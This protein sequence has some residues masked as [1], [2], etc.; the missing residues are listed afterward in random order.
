MEKV[1]YK[2]ICDQ[3]FGKAETLALFKSPDRE[4]FIRYL[5]E[6][7]VGMVMARGQAP[8]AEAEYRLGAIEAVDSVMREL[9]TLDK[10]VESAIKREAEERKRKAESVDAPMRSE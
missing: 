2:V 8:S 10:R 3:P 4:L 5:S 7:R 1:Q 9:A 6:K